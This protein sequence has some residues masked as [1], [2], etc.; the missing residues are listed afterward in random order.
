MMT[1]A[2]KH[3]LEWAVVTGSGSFPFDMLRYDA[4][5]PA[6]EAQIS[7]F[8]KYS[9]IKRRS[10][11]VGRWRCQPGEWTPERWR[12]FTWQWQG[13]FSELYEAR[14]VADRLNAAAEKG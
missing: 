2:R 5:F 12:S 4:C 14:Q 7:L 11:V 10:I 13:P 3:V 8:E 1:R 6:F 9:N